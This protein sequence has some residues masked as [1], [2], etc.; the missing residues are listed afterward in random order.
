MAANLTETITELEHQSWQALQ[1]SGSDFLPFLTHD[2]QF[3]F[4]LGM[5]ITQ[6]S[7]PDIKTIMTSE[8]F[9]PWK[10]YD[11]KDVEVIPLGPGGALISYKA[12]ATRADKEPLFRA[13]CSST[14]RK[15]SS[16]GQWL[17]CFHQQTPYDHEL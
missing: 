12:E 10:T 16:S 3:M 1:R 11:M 17:L 4:P 9:V 2:A 15:D 13:L 7:S 6:T 5:R 14:W 8:A